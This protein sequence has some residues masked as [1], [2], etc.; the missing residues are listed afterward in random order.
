MDACATG[1]VQIARL[2]MRM[3]S[4]LNLRNENNETAADLLRNYIEANRTDLSDK[5]ILQCETL[6][7]ELEKKASKRKLSVC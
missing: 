6:L 7:T 3:G 5:D 2:L 1:K 4:D